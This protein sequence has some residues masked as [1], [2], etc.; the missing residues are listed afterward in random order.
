MDTKEIKTHISQLE[1][2]NDDK[3]ILQIL[4]IMKKDIKPTEQL[5]RVSFLPITDSTSY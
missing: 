2:A 4:T 5:L 1:R 3:T